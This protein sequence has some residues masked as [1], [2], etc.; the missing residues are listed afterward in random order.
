MSC[1]TRILS[2]ESMGNESYSAHLFEVVE[3][4]VLFGPTSAN[5]VNLVL[6]SERG[7]GRRGRRLYG[8]FIE[9]GEV[10]FENART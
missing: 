3:I 8:H 9:N 4:T 1:D 5:E 10:Q 7:R 6:I 2:H